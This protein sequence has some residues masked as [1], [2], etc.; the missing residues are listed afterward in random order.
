MNLKDQGTKKEMLEEGKGRGKIILY[1]IILLVKII[2][3]KISS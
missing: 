2:I 3:R 1:I